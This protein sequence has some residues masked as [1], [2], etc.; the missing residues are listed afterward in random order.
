M[1]ALASSEVSAQ[2]AC[3]NEWDF[4]VV[5]SGIGGSTLAHALAKAGKQVLLCERG[6]PTEEAL[7]G[8]YAE[9]LLQQA[10]NPV[11]HDVFQRSG[12]ATD[13]LL[14]TNGQ[15][16]SHLFTP[17][18]GAGVGGSSALYGM[19]ME[20][21]F[22]IDFQPAQC[23]STDG[24]TLPTHWP[25]SYETLEPYYEQ[26]ER[27]Y[28][29]RGSADPLKTTRAQ[30]LKAPP[31]L[32]PA[33]QYVFQHFQ[34][35]GL[36]PYQIP[37]AMADNTNC[38]YC[39]GYLCA[40]KCKR[41]AGNVC[42]IEGPKLLTNCEVIK[43]H[44]D[45][46]RVHALEARHQGNTL[47]INGRHIILA[48]GALFTPLI[49]LNSHNKQWPEGIANESGLVGRNLMRH[50]TDVWAIR[51][52]VASDNRAKQ[53]ASNDFYW[54]DGNKLGTIQSFGRLPPT[55]VV[56][57]SLRQDVANSS[58]ALLTPLIKLISPLLR[59]TINKLVQHDTLLASIIEDLP[60]Q[61]NRIE[62][63]NNGIPRL[64]Y[65]ISAQDR[66]RI[67]LMRSHMRTLLRPLPFQL[68]K[69]AENTERIAHVCGTCRAGD[70]PG[71]S[72]VDANNR[73]HNLDNLYIVDSSFFPSSGGTNP[74]LTIAANALRVADILC[75]S[76]TS[77][78]GHAPSPSHSES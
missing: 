9:S 26:A 38:D 45:Q 7:T 58:A 4:V 29:L 60:Y 71:D 59:P 2:Q 72:V 52:D 6:T 19:A 32:S 65:Q 77:A 3:T 44:T 69:Q 8:A 47:T 36:N 46:H 49:L 51:L 76:T 24:H 62:P 15:G 20:R 21:F 11:K 75:S 54:R 42:A 16:R 63:G 34:A 10:T 22:P 41:H 13:T 37:L 25:F 43:L 12:R 53:I 39:Q 27:I 14:L 64:T 33:N 66:Q 78:P 57:A 68:L 30:H 61:H 17:F 70:S 23:F 55:D 74:S 56:L 67:T 50:Y 48:A 1:N 73:A 18:I 40:R 35:H 31:Q 5:G 28:G